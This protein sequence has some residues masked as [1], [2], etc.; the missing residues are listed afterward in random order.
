MT[1][2]T[3][4]RLLLIGNTDN[5]VHIRNFY[6]LVKAYFDEILIV[7]T[8]E[9][10]FCSSKVIQFQLTHPVRLR[11]SIASLRKIISD[12]DPTVIH[13]HQANS[14]AFITTLAN[15]GKKPMVLTTWGSDVLHLP[16]RNPFFK[17]MVRFSLT[18]AKAI[19]ADASIMAS[20]IEKLSGRKDVVL[21]NFGIDFPEQASQK[22]IKEPLIYSNRMHDSLYRID[23]IIRGCQSF[24]SD[25]PD[26]KL[27]IGG[28]GP[29]TENLKQLAQKELKPHQ[30]E[31]VGF[32]PQAENYAWYRRAHVYVSI[33]ETDG[34]AI[35]LLEAMAFGCVP[36]L[37]DLPANREWIESGSNGII[38]STDDLSNYVNQAVTLDQQRVAE[39]NKEIILQK[40]TKEANRR[41]FFSLYD[42]QTSN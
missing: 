27:V 35:S 19:T 12:F 15:R 34:T 32:I 2:H 42:Q 9:V 33:P 18:R 20:A 3:Q 11:N 1:K 24:L 14:V 5:P 10:D 21:A 7:G 31:F 16:K 22:Q 13:V 38:C 23:H 25:N 40:A 28:A 36:V 6:F 8:R 41:I 4:K 39:I 29:Q 26:W 37:S 30:V 17:W